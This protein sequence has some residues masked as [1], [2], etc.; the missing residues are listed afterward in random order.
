MVALIFSHRPS[1]DL[2]ETPSLPIV[3]RR[4]GDDGWEPDQRAPTNP[5][6]SATAADG[7]AGAADSCAAAD[8]DEH[9]PPGARAESDDVIFGVEGPRGPDPDAT[10]NRCDLDHV[11]SIDVLMFI[12]YSALMNPIERRR[13]TKGWTRPQLAEHVGVSRQAV[14]YWEKGKYLP[15]GQSLHKLAEVFEVDELD[16]VNE[17]LSWQD[18]HRRS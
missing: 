14:Y 15:V 2:S 9:S 17:L 3:L 13:Q 10:A 6:R 16:L 4:L 5:D 8:L 12:I 11:F 1:W 7:Y 18:A